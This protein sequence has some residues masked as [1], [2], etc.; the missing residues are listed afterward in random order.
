[1]RY[2]IMYVCREDVSFYQSEHVP[3][4]KS[5]ST[6]RDRTLPPP[7]RRQFFPD[8]SFYQSEHVPVQGVRLFHYFGCLRFTL[9]ADR[10]SRI[11]VSI[12]G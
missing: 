7:V 6:T 9:V 5:Y 12:T 8:V 1:M 4:I 11:I 2:D 10:A 3:L